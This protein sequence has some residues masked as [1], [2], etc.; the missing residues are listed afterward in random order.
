MDPLPVVA[1]GEELQ[2]PFGVLHCVEGFGLLAARP[3][4][5]AVEPFGVRLLDVAQSRSI[6]PQRLGR[7]GGGVDP[8]A[9]PSR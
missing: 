6:I 1:G 8:A 4:A 5:L 7:G 3:F 2:D 9:K